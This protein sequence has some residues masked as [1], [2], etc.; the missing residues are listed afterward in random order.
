[1]NYSLES[2]DETNTLNNLAKNIFSQ[3]NV[4]CLSQCSD[5][6]HVTSRMIRTIL[7]YINVMSQYV[8]IATFFTD[9]SHGPISIQL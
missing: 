1:M 2:L 3:S 7:L 6:P 4:V 8:V 5:T 9:L